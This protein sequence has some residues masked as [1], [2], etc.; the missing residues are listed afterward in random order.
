MYWSQTLHAQAEDRIHRIGSEEPCN[1]FYAMFPNSLDGMV[2]ASLRRKAETVRNVVDAAPPA[3]PAKRKPVPKV[4]PDAKG[5]LDGRTAA[6]PN[7]PPP[8]TPKKKRRI[9]EESDEEDCEMGE[10]PSIKEMKELY[11]PRLSVAPSARRALPPGVQDVD[12][13]D[14]PR[15]SAP[16]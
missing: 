1:I 9:I 7:G 5:V 15:S 12:G 4:T 10:T 14:A 3:T 11:A 6:P 16:Q 13:D 8:V 2:Y